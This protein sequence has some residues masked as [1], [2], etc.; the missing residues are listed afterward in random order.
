MSIAFA[1]ALLLGASPQAE[2]PLP[3]DTPVHCDEERATCRDGC[4]LDFGTSVDTRKELVTCLDRCDERREV[5]LLRVVAKQRE[6]AEAASRSLGP[7]AGKVKEVPGTPATPYTLPP[8]N[9]VEQGQAAQA[10]DAGEALPPAHRTA[11]KLK[12][13]MMEPTPLTGAAAAKKDAPADATPAKPA[14]GK[15]KA[16]TKTKRAKKDDSAS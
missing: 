16:K 2:A 10:P 6:Q 8:L 15:G 13:D 11:T 4:S 3:K 1:L 9:P 7:G 14:K 5:C 12:P